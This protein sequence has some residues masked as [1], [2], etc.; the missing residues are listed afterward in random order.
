MKAN[1]RKEAEIVLSSA[2]LQAEKIIAGAQT[3]RL[4]LIAEI[5]ELKRARVSFLS[6]LSSLVDSHRALLDTLRPAP[7]QSVPPPARVDDNV[8][9][10]APPGKRADHK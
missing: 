9:F 1:A 2:E 6:Q 3:R 4:Q 8:S 5:E 7:E 10:L